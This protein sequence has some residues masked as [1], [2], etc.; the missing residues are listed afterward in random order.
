MNRRDFQ[1]MLIQFRAAG[2]AVKSKRKGQHLSYKVYNHN[3]ALVFTASRLS[4]HYAIKSAV[5]VY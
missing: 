4:D 3:G 1:T 2:C 5:G